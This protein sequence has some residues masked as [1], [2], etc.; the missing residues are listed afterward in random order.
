MHICVEDLLTAIQRENNKLDI[1]NVEICKMTTALQEKH[2]EQ[3]RQK[4][5]L[6]DLVT[7]LRCLYE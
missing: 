1:L 3:N 2:N 6:M 7:E 5:V 4:E